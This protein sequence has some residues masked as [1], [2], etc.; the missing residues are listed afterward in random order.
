[1]VQRSASND[2]VVNISN[3]NNVLVTDNDNDENNII[4]QTSDKKEENFNK[5]I[6]S[7]VEKLMNDETE[8]PSLIKTAKK[9]NFYIE[10]KND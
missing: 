10:N 9:I 7:K 2:I 3:L 1:M 8:L 5:T 4:R 6:E